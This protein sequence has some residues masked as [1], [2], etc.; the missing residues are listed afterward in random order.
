M[1]KTAM[2]RARTSEE[3]KTKAEEI[4][5]ETGL[6]PSEAINISITSKSF[7]T[8]LFLFCIF[9]TSFSNCFVVLILKLNIHIPD[10]VV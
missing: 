3:T 9:K 4:L 10:K 8:F 7:L 5:K 6:N 1:S 2:I